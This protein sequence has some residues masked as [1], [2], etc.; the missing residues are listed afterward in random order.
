[1]TT[2]QPGA[3]DPIAASTKMMTAIADAQ[4]EFFERVLSAPGNEAL[5]ELVR[6]WTDLQRELLA[7]WL[8]IGGS[9]DS[10]GSVTEL[11]AAGV[12]MAEALREAAEDLIVSQGKWAKARR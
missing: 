11:R 5:A 8:A 9:P 3:P 1:M 12:Q 10:A 7:G 4:M 6:R 2:D